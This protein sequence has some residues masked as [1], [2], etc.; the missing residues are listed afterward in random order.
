MKKND[1]IK[2]LKANKNIS[3]YEITFRK[4]ESRELFYVLK[5]L[6]INRA[7]SV[8]EAAIDIYVDKDDKKGSSMVVITSADNEKTLKAKLSAAVKKALSA[9]NKHYPLA[10]KS[11]NIIEKEPKKLDLNNVATKIA[12]AVYKADTNKDGWINSCEIFVSSI[13]RELITSKGIN[14]VSYDNICQI[15]IIPTWKNK[16]E[17]YELL[18]FVQTSDFDYAKITKEA[19]EVLLLSK[20]RSKAVKASTLKLPKNIKVLVQDDMLR[21]LVGN[22]T[23]DATYEYLYLKQNH[24]KVKDTISNTKF[25]LTLYP[26]VKGCIA[27]SKYDD[28]GVN[29]SKKTIIKDGKLVDNWGGIRFGHYLGIKKPTGDIPCAVIKAPSYD[30]KKEKHIIIDHFSAPQ[31]E[32]FSGYFGGEVRL[33]RYFDGKKYIPITGFAISGNIYDA[34]KNIKFSKE[35]T[36][37]LNYSG[38]R[39][40]IF[41]KVSIN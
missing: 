17:E 10:E 23:G 38:P 7:V 2:C 1:I 34:V 18:R 35:K 24:Y 36:S 12:K 16:D 21:D 14:H 31:L 26:E 25:D 3:D 20:Y 9:M 39:Y 5:H 11:Q 32:G 28:H 15:E 29:L 27:S 30:Y 8:E 37:N 41:D 4:K 6:E 19:K 22:F 33:A 13:R 40:F